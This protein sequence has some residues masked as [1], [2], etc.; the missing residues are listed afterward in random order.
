MSRH[1]E[2][3]ASSASLEGWMRQRCLEPILRGAQ[4]RAP[5][6]DDSNPHSTF[7]STYTPHSRCCSIQPS[8]PLPAT[9]HQPAAQ[10]LTWATT[11]ACR[12]AA[13]ALVGSARSYNVANSSLVFIVITAVRRPDSS[14]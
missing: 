2:V 11:P 7:S 4:E 13:T 12:R 14:E 8:K 3:L 10:C 5:Q 9:R 1:P 6:D